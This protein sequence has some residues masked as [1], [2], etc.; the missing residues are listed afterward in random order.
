VYLEE[1]QKLQDRVPPFSNEEAKQI[2]LESLG[3]P[4]EEIFAEMSEHPIAAA[5]LGQVCTE[6][7]CNHLL[8][9]V[10]RIRGM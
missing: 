1:L 3:K 8:Y 4:A 2:I 7:R 6:L 5:S 9:Y 10:K